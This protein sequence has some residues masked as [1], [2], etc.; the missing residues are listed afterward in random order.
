MGMALSS[1]P[2]QA[3][4]MRIN[5]GGGTKRAR[6][7]S[8]CGRNMGHLPERMFPGARIGAGP[9]HTSFELRKFPPIH[10]AWI[11]SPRRCRLLYSVSSPTKRV[12]QRTCAGRQGRIPG[13]VGQQQK[14]GASAKLVP[15]RA[16]LLMRR[17]NRTGDSNVVHIDTKNF[18]NSGS[19]SNRGHQRETIGEWLLRSES[20]ISGKP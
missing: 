20:H 8:A 7:G 5:K 11:A 12:A 6:R 4:S 3:V 13:R 18:S 9:L 19:S 16:S 14:R 2:P 15:L 1:P 10:R 17:S